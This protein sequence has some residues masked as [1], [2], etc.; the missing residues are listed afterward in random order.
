[1]KRLLPLALFAIL[2]VG[3]SSGRARTIEEPVVTLDDLN[4]ARLSTADLP[5]GWLFDSASDSDEPQQTFCGYTH[6]AASIGSYVLFSHGDGEMLGEVITLYP[7]EDTAKQAMDDIAAL[8]QSC[9]PTLD[10]IG[11]INFVPLDFP[12]LGDDTF[13]MQ[14]DGVNSID[15]VYVRKGNTLIEILHT[16]PDA[17]EQDTEELTRAA[18]DKLP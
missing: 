9:R 16:E 2:L 6:P 1:M 12:R 18:V 15:T 11:D 8:G 4:S 3:C 5:T 14:S 13:A 17:A 7:D 10:G